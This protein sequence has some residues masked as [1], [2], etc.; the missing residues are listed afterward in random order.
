MI[1]FIKEQIIHRFG[2]PQS[3]TIDQGTMF[4]GDE[5]TYFAKEQTIHRFGIPQSIIINQGTMF[6]GDELTYFAKD[7]GIQLIRSPP[8]YAQENGQ[9]KVSNKV[10]IDILE[11]MLEDNLKYW[12]K[13]LFETLWVDRTSKRDSTGISPYSL[14]YGQDEV[15]PMEVVVPSLK[16]SRQNDLN[17]QEYSAAM[18]MELEALDE[19]RL[20]ALDHIMI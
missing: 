11:K 5:L 15:L 2:I 8:F 18:M 10:L 6:T 19:K 13:I 4:T 3:I 20:Q 17:L 14:T 1:Q 12:H 9:A 7:Y 16:V